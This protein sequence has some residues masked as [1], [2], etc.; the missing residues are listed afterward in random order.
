[1]NRYDLIDDMTDACASATSSAAGND[2]MARERPSV[3]RLKGDR[4]NPENDEKEEA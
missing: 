1:M 3:R 4:C 2:K